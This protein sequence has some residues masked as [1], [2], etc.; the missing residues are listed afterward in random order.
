MEKKIAC[1][2]RRILPGQEMPRQQA[3]EK[4]QRKAHRVA[5]QAP[6]QLYRKQF[7]WKKELFGLAIVKVLQDMLVGSHPKER[8]E[9]INDQISYRFKTRFICFRKRKERR[10]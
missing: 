7:R 5:I 6:F 2:L 9:S 4:S 3:L 8:V 1:F 10:N